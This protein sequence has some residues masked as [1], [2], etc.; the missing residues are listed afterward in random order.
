MS[1]L[2]KISIISRK[3]N[4]LRGVGEFVI[5]ACEKKINGNNY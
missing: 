2:T 3:E 4:R 1:C 5:R